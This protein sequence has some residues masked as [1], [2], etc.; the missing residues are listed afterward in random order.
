MPH[1][2]T[3]CGSANEGVDTDGGMAM[4]TPITTA[5][6]LAAALVMTMQIL[7]GC[8]QTAKS[9]SNRELR[10]R[11]MVVEFGLARGANPKEGVGAVS[12]AGNDLYSSNIYK[13]GIRHEL[14]FGAS[15]N[16]SFPRW[17]NV[18]W[19]KGPGVDLDLEH[20]GF[21]GG[22]VVGNYK[23]E[24]LS[25]IPDEVFRYVSASRNRAIVL[26]F[27]IEDDGVLLA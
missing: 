23:V 6:F 5:T 17:V 2:T 11:G 10:G 20:G 27:R 18:T 4:K 16:M 3:P 9:Q 13:Q 14:S 8:A 25:R 7:T 26:R 22:T 1:G 21:S 19:R 15:S 24:V 12:D